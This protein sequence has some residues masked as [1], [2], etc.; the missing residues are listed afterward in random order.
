MGCLRQAL[1]AAGTSEQDV[2]K[3]GYRHT[4]LAPGGG[5]LSTF[6]I[7]VGLVGTDVG[8]V[9]WADGRKERGAWVMM[10]GTRELD[11]DR[12]GD[13]DTLLYLSVAAHCLPLQVL[14]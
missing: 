14:V 3:E 7:G 11:T 10:V 8:L 13:T 1:K 12:R 5:P 6:V 9:L 4:S 2:D